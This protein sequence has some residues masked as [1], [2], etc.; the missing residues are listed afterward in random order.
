MG[1]E[2]AKDVRH[3]V[4]GSAIAVGISVGGTASKE[5]P[6][7]QA[8]RKEIGAWSR[9]CWGSGGTRNSGG[10]GD[11]DC[12]CGDTNTRGCYSVRNLCSGDWA[13]GR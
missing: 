6:G 7:V 13:D 10:T 4:R 8:L 11:Q 1:G 3:K 9:A 12:A 5:E 2:T